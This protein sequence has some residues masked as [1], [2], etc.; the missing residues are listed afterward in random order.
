MTDKMIYTKPSN[1]KA[2]K[3]FNQDDRI[4]ALVRFIARCAAENDYKKLHDLIEKDL[5]E[6]T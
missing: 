4:R 6:E 5:E 2:I 1:K 3:P